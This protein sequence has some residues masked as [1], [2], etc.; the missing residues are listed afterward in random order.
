MH[1]DKTPL[2]GVVGTLGTL[3]LSDVH[4]LV[5]IVAGLATVAYVLT[6]T[7]LLVRASRQP[8][9]REDK[10]QTRFPFDR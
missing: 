4:T 5:G 9:S 2:V 8:G 10:S 3:T 1:Y 6:K 7:V